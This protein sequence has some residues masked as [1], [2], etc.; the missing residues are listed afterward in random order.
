MLMAQRLYIQTETL[1]S[2]FS[3][4]YRDGEYHSN[5]DLNGVTVRVGIE[6]RPQL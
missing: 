3:E 5:I 2:E 1:A 4:K 6:R